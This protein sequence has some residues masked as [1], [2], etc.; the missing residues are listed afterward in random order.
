[1][2]ATTCAIIEYAVFNITYMLT[3]Q[4]LVAQGLGLFLALIFGYFGHTFYTFRLNKFSRTN[5]AMYYFQALIMFG[6]GYAILYFFIEIKNIY[7]PTA[8]FFQMAI[9]FPI[10]F[11]I[12]NFISFR[13]HR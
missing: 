10:N 7:Y 11:L 13:I 9:V 2:V 5:M 8:K 3:Y 1:M 6:L 4:L 12:G